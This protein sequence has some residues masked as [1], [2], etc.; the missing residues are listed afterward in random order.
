MFANS[1]FRKESSHLNGGVVEHKA[2]VLDGAI[3]DE[4]HVELV[5]A[6]EYG[7]RRHTGVPAVAPQHRGVAVVTVSDLE[8]VVVTANP[9]SL[10]VKIPTKLDH[11]IDYLHSGTLKLLL[12]A[13]WNIQVNT[14]TH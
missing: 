9:S 14:S 12:K 10:N 1:L 6:G 8:V 4:C 7:V 5:I 3:G 2:P 11:F 13:A